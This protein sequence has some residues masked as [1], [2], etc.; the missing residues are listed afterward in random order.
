MFAEVFNCDSIEKMLPFV[1]LY[2]DKPSINGRTLSAGFGFPN[3]AKIS[4]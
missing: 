2:A 4:L 3:S 1:G